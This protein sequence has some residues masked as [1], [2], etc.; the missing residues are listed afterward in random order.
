MREPTGEIKEF[1]KLTDA[2]VESKEWHKIPEGIEAAVNKLNR[3]ERRFMAQRL[4]KGETTTKAYQS[5]LEQR[6]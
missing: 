6:G 4:A 2:E 3:K 1:D 5:V